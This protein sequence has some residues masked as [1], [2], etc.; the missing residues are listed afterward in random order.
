M[1]R[2]AWRPVSRFEA[3]MNRGVKRIRDNAVRGF[4]NLVRSAADM[5]SLREVTQWGPRYPKRA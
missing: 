4:G 1:G 5:P 2:R 3:P